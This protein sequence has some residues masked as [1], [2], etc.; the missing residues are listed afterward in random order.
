MGP[1]YQHGLILIPAWISNQKPSKV[2]EEIT[3]PFLTFNGCTVEVLEWISIF[4]PHIKMHE[5]T[6]LYGD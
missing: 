4:I 5:I 2:W 6:Y 1:F 3:Y